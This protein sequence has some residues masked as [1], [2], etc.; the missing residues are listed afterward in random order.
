MCD[1]EIPA[2]RERIMARLI[3]PGRPMTK[4]NSEQIIRNAR[5]GKP[6]I[7]QSPQY[8]RYEEACL[9]YLLSFRAPRFIGQVHV[10]VSYWMPNRR[11]WPDLIGLE[12]ST[13]D[14]L[15][16]AKIIVNDRDIVSWDG[17]R[18][19]GVDKDNPRT[20]IEIE[21]VNYHDHQARMG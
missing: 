1:S 17:S 4:K 7:I 3:L 15:E 13:A 11:S 10:T 19:A 16:R 9:W 5:S 6:G 14:I 20:A 8:R 21:E 2:E 18:I 12:Q